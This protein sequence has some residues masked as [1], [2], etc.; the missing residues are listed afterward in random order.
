MSTACGT[1]AHTH[2]FPEKTDLDKSETPSGSDFPALGRTLEHK[3]GRRR[4]DCRRLAAFPAPAPLF[5]ENAEG[6]KSG[7]GLAAAVSRSKC[8]TIEFVTPARLGPAP[9]LSPPVVPPSRG[10]SLPLPYRA[11]HGTRQNFSESVASGPGTGPR[12]VWPASFPDPASPDRHHEGSAR[13]KALDSGSEY[14]AQR[15]A[16]AFPPA[17]RRAPPDSRRLRTPRLCPALPRPQ[18]PGT[19]SASSR[20]SPCALRP[21]PPAPP[22]SPRRWRR[23]PAL[24]IGPRAVAPR[25]S[26]SAAAVGAAPTGQAA[27]GEA[28]V[29]KLASQ[30]SLGSSSGGGGSFA[31]GFGD[32]LARLPCPS[33]CSFQTQALAAHAA[34]DSQ[35]P[36]DKAGLAPRPDSQGHRQ[37]QSSPLVLVLARRGQTPTAVTALAAAIILLQQ[38][39]LSFS[40][41]AADTSQSRRATPGHGRARPRPSSKSTSSALA[42]IRPSTSSANPGATGPR[43][44]GAASLHREPGRVCSG[45]LPEI[46]RNRPARPKNTKTRNNARTARP[47]LMGRWSQRRDFPAERK[48]QYY[49]LVLSSQADAEKHALPLLLPG[50]ATLH[51]ARAQ[52]PGPSRTWPRAHR[53]RA[54]DLSLKRTCPREPDPHGSPPRAGDKRGRCKRLRSHVHGKRAV[55]GVFGLQR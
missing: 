42:S 46:L 54:N 6:S 8:V 43:G 47:L 50:R 53:L 2:A 17:R 49:E 22:T 44:H 4:S 7:E 26:Q 39:P 20:S 29:D 32:R 25:H 13:N 21:P 45:T 40:W 36:G 37:A 19:S 38:L 3:S 41:C 23:V 52:H 11:P 9:A 16:R 31:G 10:S 51:Q 34:L 35:S 48:A 30:R 55:V 5:A 28:I 18:P 24:P 14:P 12:G 15:R 33:L 27:K 1:G